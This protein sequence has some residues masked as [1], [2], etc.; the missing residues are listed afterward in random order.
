MF[1]YL[2][3][4]V[5]KPV[6]ICSLFV[7]TNLLA[8]YCFISPEHILCSGKTEGNKTGPACENTGKIIS[9]LNEKNKLRLV[10]LHNNFRR[11]IA[12]G[13]VDGYPTAA[14][15]LKMVSNC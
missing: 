10:T 1:L 11:R 3:Q 6:L 12:L 5:F 14:D 9:G 4:E 8:Y 13:E 15:M 2:R 7:N